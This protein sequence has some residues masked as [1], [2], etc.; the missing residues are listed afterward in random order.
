MFL[1]SLVALILEEDKQ[2]NDGHDQYSKKQDIGWAGKKQFN[3][4][5][6]AGVNFP[7]LYHV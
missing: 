4:G 7:D 2:T 1:P 3:S 5:R 6:F